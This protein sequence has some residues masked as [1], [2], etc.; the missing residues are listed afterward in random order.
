MQTAT[1]QMGAGGFKLTLWP[2]EGLGSVRHESGKTGV[3]SGVIAKL[4]GQPDDVRNALN[5]RPPFFQIFPQ[6]A[7]C[8]FLK[9]Q[10][11]SV[12]G[13]EDSPYLSFCPEV[14]P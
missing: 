5:K 8:F 10:Q 14:P 6:G 1:R 13:K 4:K 11:L 12:N 3:Q 2:A 9:K 7:P